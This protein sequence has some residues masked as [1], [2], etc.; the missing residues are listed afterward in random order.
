MYQNIGKKIKMLVKVCTYF[1]GI[2]SI[3]AGIIVIVVALNSYDLMPALLIGIALA[4]IAPVLIWINSLVMYGFGELVDCAQQLAESLPSS[5][6]LPPQQ[7]TP[8]DQA[9]SAPSGKEK[10]DE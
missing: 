7:L 1:L 3:V 10:A 4:V 5:G 8:P 2:S 9:K 6:V